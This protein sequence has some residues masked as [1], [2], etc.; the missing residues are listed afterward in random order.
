MEFEAFHKYDGAPGINDVAK[1]TAAI[2]TGDPAGAC[3]A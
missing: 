2:I 3:P 1:D